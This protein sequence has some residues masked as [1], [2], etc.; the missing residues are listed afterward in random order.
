MMRL[1]LILM[2]LA[3]ACWVAFGLIGSEV[4]ENGVLQEPFFLLGGGWLLMLAGAGLV[5]FALVTRFFR[6]G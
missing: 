6:R 5:L 1:G 3:A 2:I 4:D